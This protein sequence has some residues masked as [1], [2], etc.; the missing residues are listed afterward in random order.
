MFAEQPMQLKDADQHFQ[1][2]LPFVAFTFDQDCETP[3]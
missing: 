1:L 3:L 2:E